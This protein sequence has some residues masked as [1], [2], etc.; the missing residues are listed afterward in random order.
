MRYEEALASWERMNADHNTSERRRREMIEVGIY[1]DTDVMEEYL[2]TCLSSVAWPRETSIGMQILQDGIEIYLDIDLPE[3]EQMPNTLAVPHKRG[4]RVA[5]KKVSTA[6]VRRIYRDHV[7]GVGFRACGEAFAALPKAQRVIVSAYSQR[8]DPATGRAQDQYLY[9]ARIAR[10]VWMRIDFGN[11]ERLDV[12]EAFAEF[13][14]R[15]DMT[16]RGDFRPIEPFA[17]SPR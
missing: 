15:R 3:L 5:M 13:D 16:K 2:E 7:H 10:H 1:S 8:V 11:L 12:S 17:P 6:R 14:L 4:F 9:S